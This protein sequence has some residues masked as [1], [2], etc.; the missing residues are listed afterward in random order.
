[1]VDDAIERV[2]TNLADNP[3]TV[4]NVRHIRYLTSVAKIEGDSNNALVEV[5]A[6]V[7]LLRRVAGSRP[8]QLILYR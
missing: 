8:E 4:L 2:R 5:M 7:S 1:M 3:V 6:D